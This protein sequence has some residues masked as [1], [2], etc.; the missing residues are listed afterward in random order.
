MIDGFYIDEIITD[1]VS[2]VFQIH[3]RWK[4]EE[5]NYWVF[6]G[7]FIGNPDD[8]V[9]LLQDIFEPLKF[10]VAVREEPNGF[11]KV[12][13][14][15]APAVKRD[16]LW[17]NV[18]LFVLTLISTFWVGSIM[19]LS[20]FPRSFGEFLLGYEFAIP[21]L[22]ILGIHELGHYYMA[23]KHKVQST[24]PYFIPFP[25]N[26]VG[27]LGAFIKLKS[28]IPSKK[29]LL[30]I[31]IAGPIAGFVIA[32]PV[33]IFG[34]KHSQL[35][36]LD[37]VTAS[38]FGIEFGEPLIFMILRYLT[39]GASSFH[40]YP[41]ALSPSAFAA[42]VGFF[43]TSLNLLPVG[44]L[45][46]GHILYSVADKWHKD[47]SRL[48]VLVLILLGFFWA[49]WLIWGFLLIILGIRHPEPLNEITRLDTKR[50][51]LAFL[52]LILLILT[53]VPAPVR[54]VR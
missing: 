35:Y 40:N 49:G 16:K 20:R 36:P 25:F 28:P 21:L 8:G 41:V 11:Y 45:D 42:W 32:I 6:V 5:Q 1:A 10:L 53:F 19:A 29:A 15:K 30:D 3:D 52:A 47:I 48:F 43:V 50:R 18:L 26:M 51:W 7:R 12:V 37:Y 38:R 23:R 31:G 24:L 54:V 14:M 4:L 34:L 22:L 27:T 9:E 39:L 13:I 2:R 33:A 46:G 17:I 44:Q